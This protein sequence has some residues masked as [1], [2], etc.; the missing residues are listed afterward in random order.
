MPILAQRRQKWQCTVSNK[1]FFSIVFQYIWLFFFTQVK[2]YMMLPPRVFKE[3]DTDIFARSGSGF[4]T[5]K[6][7][8][9]KN[10]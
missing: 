1:I 2:A 10:N 7:K 3:T 8:N 9:E 4:K 5:K 6:T